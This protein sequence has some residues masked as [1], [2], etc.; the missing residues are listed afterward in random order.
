MNSEAII[1]TEIKPY[2]VEA[3]GR[4]TANSLITQG[5]LA[6]VSTDGGE[7]ERFDALL[8]AI[9]T[10]ARVV[11]EWG[12]EIA[13]EQMDKWR[14]AYAGHLARL[15]E[16]EGKGGGTMTARIL[17]GREMAK[18]VRQEVNAD[19]AAFGEKHGFTPTIAVV[20]AG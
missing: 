8:R 18:E 16:L 17:D 13:A 2:L 7:E 5:T 14:R 6:Y 12:A 9:S 1:A 15:K 20:R 3:F 19:V 10:D 4:Q 11:R